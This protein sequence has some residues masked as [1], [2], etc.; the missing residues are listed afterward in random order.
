MHKDQKVHKDCK[1]PEEN[2]ADQACIL[3]VCFKIERKKNDQTNST[4]YRKGQP[5]ENGQ[6]GPAG[7]DGSQGEK[8]SPGAAGLSGPPGFPGA[9]GAPGL[10]GSPGQPGVKGAPVSI[11]RVNVYPRRPLTWY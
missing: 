10:S 9:R 1:D 6:P 5:G 2:L 8:G 4:F 7:K 3:F 11:A